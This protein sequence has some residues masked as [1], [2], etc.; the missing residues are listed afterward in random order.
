[1]PTAVYVGALVGLN[2]EC[3]ARDGTCSTQFRWGIPLLGVA[4]VV[5]KIGWQIGTEGVAIAENISLGCCQKGCH[6]HDAQ[7]AAGE[8]VLIHNSCGLGFLSIVEVLFLHRLKKVKLVPLLDC[9]L[10][11]FIKV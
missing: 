7:P 5:Q 6:H 8:K 9:Y 2:I 4:V 3:Y 10:T 11:I 1:M